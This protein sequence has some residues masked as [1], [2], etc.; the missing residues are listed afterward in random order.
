M[1]SLFVLAVAADGE[2]G[3]VRK[4]GEG[5]E[6]AAG[7]GFGHFGFVALREARPGFGIVERGLHGAEEGGA[8]REVREPDV[9][10]VVLRKP[11]LRDAARRPPDSSQS[12]SFIGSSGCAESNDSDCHGSAGQNLR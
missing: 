8:G 6:E 12:H 7:I 2:V 1:A 10:P 9:V 11:G 5:V 4:G 3:V